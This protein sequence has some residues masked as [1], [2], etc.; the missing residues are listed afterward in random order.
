M[1]LKFEHSYSELLSSNSECKAAFPVICAIMITWNS[2]E[3]SSRL[4]CIPKV[5]QN[6]WIVLGNFIL[7]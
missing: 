2:Q 3:L 7:S 6:K 4:L 5:T 1:Y